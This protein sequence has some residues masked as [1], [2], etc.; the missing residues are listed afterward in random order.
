MN[1]ANNVLF[2]KLKC[3]NLLFGKNRIFTTSDNKGVLNNLFGN[4][5]IFKLDFKFRIFFWSQILISVIENF[6]ENQWI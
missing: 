1:Y 5:Q 4:I 6:S 2:W 3:K